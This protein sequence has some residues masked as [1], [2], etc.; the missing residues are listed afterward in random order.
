MSRVLPIRY[1]GTKEWMV[2]ELIKRLPKNLCYYLE[3][4]CGRCDFFFAIS[5]RVEKAYL[6]DENEYLINAIKA[7]KYDVKTLIKKLEIHERNK[8]EQYYY[9]ILNN[10]KLSHPLWDASVFFHVMNN[11]YKGIFALSKKTGKFKTRWWHKSKNFNKECKEDLLWC[12]NVLNEKAVIECRDFE[13]AIPPS[14]SFVFFDPPYLKENK[15]KNGYTPDNGKIWESFDLDDQRRLYRHILRLTKKNVNVM[16]TNLN[17]GKIRGIY[18]DPIFRHSIIGRKS[19]I[20]WKLIEELII[21]NYKTKE[22]SMSSER[23]EHLEEELRIANYILDKGNIKLEL[24]R[25]FYSGIVATLNY[26][27]GRTKDSPS[28]SHHAG[29]SFNGNGGGV[30][31]NGRKKGAGGTK[32][33]LPPDDLRSAVLEWVAKMGTMKFAESSK[34]PLSAVYLIR[35]NKPI[36]AY[37]VEKYTKKIEALEEGK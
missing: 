27:S 26:M 35:K 5:D 8:C 31:K 14:G 11:C 24:D 4:F 34:I 2:D 9:Y 7:V 23:L 30:K 3:L 28:L 25:G 21:T 29:L 19:C 10:S 33:V 18:K 37:V 6:S 13:Y 17:C 15:F 12:S 1:V 20:T 36:A 22:G 32:T 16:T